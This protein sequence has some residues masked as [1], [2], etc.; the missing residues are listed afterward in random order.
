MFFSRKT[1][2]VTRE[3]ALPGRPTPMPVNGSHVVLGT[4][5]V[6]PWPALTR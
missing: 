2:M 3:E 1:E 4:P 6:G 5:T